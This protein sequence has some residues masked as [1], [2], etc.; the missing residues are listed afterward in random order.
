MQVAIVCTALLGLLL[1]LLGLAVS[2]TRGRT[3]VIAGSSN[4]PA[5]S[6][7]KLVRAH[8]NTAEYAPMLAVL[9]LLVGERNPATWTLWAMGIAVLSRYLI[10]V[11]MIIGPTLA[12][13]YPL[14]FAGALGTYA[15]GI[16]LCI[17]AFMTPA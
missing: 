7:Y 14:R 8:G 13:P 10:A 5:D 6:L 15:T 4:D 17:A 2:M 3:G 1:F 12:K 11:G 9:F 16:V